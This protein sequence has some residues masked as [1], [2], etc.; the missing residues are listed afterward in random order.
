MAIKIKSSIQVP[1]L[2]LKRCCS[3]CFLVVHPCFEFRRR[4]KLVRIQDRPRAAA[5]ENFTT[6]FIDLTSQNLGLKDGLR[7]PAHF[8]ARLI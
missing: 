4:S 1:A 8:L 5:I 2:A 6:V 7:L 3:N